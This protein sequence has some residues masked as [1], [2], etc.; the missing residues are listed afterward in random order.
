MPSSEVRR[1][2]ARSRSFRLGKVAVVWGGGHYG[3][4]STGIGW[5]GLSADMPVEGGEHEM[6]AEIDVTFQ[7][8]Q[9]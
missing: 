4:S 8:E 5:V 9:G 3:G 2:G 1:V 7:L 6:V